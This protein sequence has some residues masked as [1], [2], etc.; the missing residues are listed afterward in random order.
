MEQLAAPPPLA[1]RAVYKSNLLSII[2]AIRHFFNCQRMRDANKVGFNKPWGGHSNGPEPLERRS[3]NITAV[4]CSGS[5]GPESSG[6]TKST[7]W[8]LNR[9]RKEVLH[10]SAV[11]GP[12]GRIRT[13]QSS[14]PVRQNW[15]WGRSCPTHRF[16]ETDLPDTK[17]WKCWGVGGYQ[18]QLV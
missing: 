16:P 11:T 1:L 13:E 12:W 17:H 9:S 10:Y 3:A 5:V 15:G 4:M 2:M 7:L 6:G 18:G 8:L 14:R